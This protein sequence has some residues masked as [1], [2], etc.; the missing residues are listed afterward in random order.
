MVQ[1]VL[2]G[3]KHFLI[4]SERGTITDL[5]IVAS[6]SGT[7]KVGS[8]FPALVEIFRRLGEREI[9]SRCFE[10]FVKISGSNMAKLR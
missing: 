2:T 7:L 9:E 5:Y 6:V 1:T 8:V 3:S 4:L 10:P